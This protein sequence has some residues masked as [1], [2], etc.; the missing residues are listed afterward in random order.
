M[1]LHRHPSAHCA[2]PCGYKLVPVVVASC[3][4]GLLWHTPAA[5]RWCMQ[6]LRDLSGQFAALHMEPFG[7][8]DF[9]KSVL[10]GTEADAELLF[11]LRKLMLRHSKKHIQDTGQWHLPERKVELVPVRVTDEEWGAYV[12]I[13]TL[14]AQKFKVYA[15]AGADCCNK[16]ILRIMSLLQPLRRLCSGGT[17]RLDVLEESLHEAP[18]PDAAVRDTEGPGCPEADDECAVCMEEHQDAVK[19]RC[20]HWFCRE[21]IQDAISLNRQCPLCRAPVAVDHL[22]AAVYPTPPA[23]LAAGT[24]HAPN[25]VH[26]RT[27][28][29]VLVE[30]LRAMH[31]ADANNKAL[32]FTQFNDTLHLVKQQ[33]EEH[34][35]GCRSICG[36]MP[37][38]QRAAAIEAFQSDPP[39]TVFVLSVRAAAVGITLTSANYVFMIEP[40]LN[41]ALHEQAVGRAWRMGQKRP[42]TVKRLFLKG[43]VEE[44]IMEVA[45]DRQVRTLHSTLCDEGIC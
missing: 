22:V 42:V 45:Q 29:D 44:A 31:E 2:V 27:K 6:D 13:H 17:H 41:T 12:R 30:Q 35:F 4:A 10:R 14:V 20:N 16:N 21:C 1:G 24:P 36:K 15:D 26:M 40:L 37:M 18:D 8:R 33:L 34:G 25:S 9:A 23:T 38:R 43:S 3:R 32:V 28:I 7:D 19:T 5:S 11:V 39:T